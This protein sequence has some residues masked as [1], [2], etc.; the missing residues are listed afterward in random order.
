MNIKE[1][2]KQDVYTIHKLAH[3][4][5]WP[6]YKPFLSEEQIIFML[7]QGYSVT[8][9]EEQLTDGVRFILAE[10]DEAIVAFAGFSSD[11]NAQICK[12]HKLYILPT[13]QGKGTGRKMIQHVSA[14]AK[15]NGAE[16]LE[17]NVNRNN[18]AFGFYKAIGFEIFQEIDIPY[19]GF[20]LNDF[21][22]RMNLVNSHC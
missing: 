9:L 16:I 12:L 6:T 20:V 14:L 2:S 8:A 10:R 15:K 21:V 17:L 5:W 3:E 13:E 18:P 19:H 11:L 1:A 7:D 4:I 22:L